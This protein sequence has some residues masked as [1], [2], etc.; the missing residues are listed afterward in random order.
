MNIRKEYFRD[1]YKRNK[2]K[3]KQYS[4]D[5]RKNNK[6]KKYLS[7]KEYRHSDKGA[8]ISYIAGAKN[9]GLLFALTKDD[10]LKYK[11][12]DCSYCGD[13]INGYGLDRVDNSLGYLIDNVVSCCERCNRM[14]L[15]MSK[16]D[17]ITQCKKIIDNTYGGKT[18]HF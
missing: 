4:R 8:F 3:F 16:E 9:R 5:W 10:F 6:D 14:K 2:E 11:N 17:F 1:R 13:K 15:T 7:C 12:N 18:N